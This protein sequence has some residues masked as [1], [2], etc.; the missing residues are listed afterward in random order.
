MFFPHIPHGH[1]ANPSSFKVFL[2]CHLFSKAYPSC[3]VQSCYSLS[4]PALLI[5]LLPFYLALELLFF[6]LIENM[7]FI[8]SLFIPMDMVEYK[9]H[10]QDSV[11][12]DQCCVPRACVSIWYIDGVW[13]IFTEWIGCLSYP[14]KS[15]WRG[16][17]GR[18][19]PHSSWD[20]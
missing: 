15:W 8:C 9:V 18:R 19:S 11:S 6:F 4:L 17:H 20:L 1:M 13:W 12:F 14:W 5:S 16:S 3:L 2:K 10:R 7:C